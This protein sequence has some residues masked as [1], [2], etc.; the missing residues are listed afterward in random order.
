MDQFIV[1]YHVNHLHSVVKDVPWNK[2]Y[3][4][5]AGHCRVCFTIRGIFWYWCGEHVSFRGRFPDLCDF[6]SLFV[7]SIFTSNI[8]HHLLLLFYLMIGYGWSVLLLCTYNVYNVMLYFSMYY[9]N[10][11]NMFTIFQYF[12]NELPLAS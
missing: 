5:P 3:V 2:I 8:M 4:F 10:S 11:F 6:F 9:S 12:N 7:L 1:L